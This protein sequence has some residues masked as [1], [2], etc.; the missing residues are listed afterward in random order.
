MSVIRL[1]G[2]SGSRASR[3]EGRRGYAGAS[4][5]P[6][7]PHG[8]TRLSIRLWNSDLDWGLV[9]RTGQAG[10]RVLNPGE[11]SAISHRRRGAE[12]ERAE[13]NHTRVTWAGA[14]V[15]HAAITCRVGRSSG[16]S[17]PWTPACFLRATFVLFGHGPLVHEPSPS[18]LSCPAC[19]SVC[20]CCIRHIS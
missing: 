5:G 14:G 13:E 10:I 7:S 6:C 1:R 17:N 3:R 2:R 19:M 4:V 8:L 9:W 11:R 16:S 15:L 20:T 18:T 12:P